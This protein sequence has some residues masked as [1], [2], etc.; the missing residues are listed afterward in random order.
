MK[1]SILFTRLALHPPAP[2]VLK[3]L[4]HFRNI[5]Q[6][7]YH[8]QLQLKW[9]GFCYTEG[10]CRNLDHT[11]SLP[12]LLPQYYKLL[13]CLYWFICVYLWLSTVYFMVSSNTDCDFIQTIFHLKKYIYLYEWMTYEH[14]MSLK[15][16]SLQFR[17]FCLIG[18][19]QYLRYFL[20]YW[21]T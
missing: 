12:L 8:S 11:F 17:I 5:I 10:F 16:N 4:D 3:R 6:I 18:H 1:L 9:S 7:V 15:M 13:F 14:G 20:F 19:K 21:I 2:S